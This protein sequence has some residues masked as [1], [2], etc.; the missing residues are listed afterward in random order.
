MRG[1]TGYEFDERQRCGREIEYLHLV[2]ALYGNHLVDLDG[3]FEAR[4]K[5]SAEELQHRNS[6]YTKNCRGGNVPS[7]AIGKWLHISM[8]NDMRHGFVRQRDAD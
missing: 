7:S 6:L 5:P 4:K 3:V 2:N 1:D 8:R